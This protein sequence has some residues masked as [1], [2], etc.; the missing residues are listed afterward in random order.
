MEQDN[1]SL[2]TKNLPANR[3]EQEVDFSMSKSQKLVTALYLITSFFSDREPLK[4]KLRNLGS[5][6][7]SANMLLKDRSS[8]KH[9]RGASDMHSIILEITSLLLILKQAGLVSEMN[10]SIINQ[11]F[12]ALLDS[13]PLSEEFEPGSPNLI[14]KD[15]FAIK[16]LPPQIA[17]RITTSAPR[18]LTTQ[19][20]PIKDKNTDDLK[21]FSVVAVKKNSRQ[22]I[23]INLLKRKKEIMIK[24]VSPLIDG[25]SEKTIQRELLSMVNSGI[26]NKVGEKRWSRYSL[27]RS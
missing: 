14:K 25:C 24:D 10:H 17:S 6:L 12:L 2:G 1:Q 19:N 27:A 9:D 3:Q 20:H 22:S 4:W 5:R 15:F 23:I 26:L 18:T 21:D 7:I 13:I 11:E 16:E 8:N